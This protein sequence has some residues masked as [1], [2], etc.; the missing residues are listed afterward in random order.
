MNKLLIILIY[1]VCTILINLF[2]A[3]AIEIYETMLSCYLTIIV[4]EMKSMKNKANGV[5]SSKYVG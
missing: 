3:L 5:H 1:V 4:E 2:P